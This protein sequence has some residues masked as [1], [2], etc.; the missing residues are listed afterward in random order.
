VADSPPAVVNNNGH[1]IRWNAFV[2]NKLQ[3]IV[4]K[5]K[6]DL[7]P[8]VGPTYAAKWKTYG[9]ENAEQIVATYLMEGTEN[10]AKICTD[11]V[12]MKQAGA[13]GKPPLYIQCLYY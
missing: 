1:S 2:N 9:C 7:L 8:G 12:G 10:F 5:K 13:T 3:K 4:G 11:K 6:A